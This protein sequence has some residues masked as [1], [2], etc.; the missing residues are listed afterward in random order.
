MVTI[1]N[2]TSEDE[3]G[4]V[5]K[6][7]ITTLVYDTKKEIQLIFKKPIYTRRNCSFPVN[8]IFV[9]QTFLLQQIDLYLLNLKPT[10][11]K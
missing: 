7:S 9:N 8:E 2:V 1:V 6:I 10:R 5:Y 4:Y 3:T 11:T